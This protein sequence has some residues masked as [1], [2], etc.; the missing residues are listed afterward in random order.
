MSRFCTEERT[1]YTSV[2]AE[3]GLS[4]RKRETPR[5]QVPRDRT[6]AKAA[7]GAG[8]GLG[9]SGLWNIPHPKGRCRV[10][11]PCVVANIA[12]FILVI[13]SH[14]VALFYKKEARI[15]KLCP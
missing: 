6:E 2:I 7:H 13:C 9:D 14:F 15:T 4:S 10:P 11:V 3:E 1:S 8:V 5:G 12:D